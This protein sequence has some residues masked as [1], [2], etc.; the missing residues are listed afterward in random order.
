[1]ASLIGFVRL[2]E[3]TMAIIAV[4]ILAVIALSVALAQGL[5]G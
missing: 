3:R 1:V 4:A 2:G 5:A